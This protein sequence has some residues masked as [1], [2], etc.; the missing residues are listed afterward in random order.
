VWFHL[1]GSN[2]YYITLSEDYTDFKRTTAAAKAL[3]ID[4]KE[5]DMSY[6][7][8]PKTEH[9]QHNIISETFLFRLDKAFSENKCG[10][11]DGLNI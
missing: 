11:S 10:N 8:I 3:G 9:L 6:I 1:I 4:F 7:F 5:D 2:R